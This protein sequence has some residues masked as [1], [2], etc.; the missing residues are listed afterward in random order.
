MQ[1]RFKP[2]E[3]GRICEH[4]LAEQPSVDGASRRFDFW[5]RVSNAPNPAAT[6]REEPM[7]HLIGIEQGDA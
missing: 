4:P 2:G 3:S 5:K 7:D 6:G 1:N